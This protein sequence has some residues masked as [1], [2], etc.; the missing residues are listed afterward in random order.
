MKNKEKLEEK[1]ETTFECNRVISFR[2]SFDRVASE[3]AAVLKKK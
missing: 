2:I 3:F 1:I